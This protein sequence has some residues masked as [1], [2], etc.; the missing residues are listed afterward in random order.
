MNLKKLILCDID[1]TMVINDSISKEN[2]DRVKDLQRLGHFV[3][4]ATGRHYTRA[5]EVIEELDIKIPMICSNGAVVYHPEE[6]KVL[7]S[8]SI[9]NKALNQCISLCKKMS[10]EYILYVEENMLA[11]ESSIKELHKLYEETNVAIIDEAYESDVLKTD[12]IVKILVVE[13]DEQKLNRV[14]NELKKIKELDC[15]ISDPGLLNVG[16]SKAT[17]GNGL[18]YLLDYLNVHQEH[19]IALGNADN[20]ISMIEAAGIGVC[21]GHDSLTLRDKS[22]IHIKD[23]LEI[24]FSKAIDLINL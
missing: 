15:N 23:N 11:S 20:D 8:Y 18:K 22:D 2:I 5:L 1:G 16:A 12:R 14:F 10:I 21:V 3:T 13:Y 6:D 7:E 24:A 4:L 17:K 19:S 9:E